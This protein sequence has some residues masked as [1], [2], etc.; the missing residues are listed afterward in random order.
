LRAAAVGTPCPGCG[1]PLDSSAE[2]D[3]VLALSLGG[4]HTAENLRVLCH[5]CHVVK[6]RADSVLLGRAR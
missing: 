2:A 6:T 1:A 5:D 4:S 3:H